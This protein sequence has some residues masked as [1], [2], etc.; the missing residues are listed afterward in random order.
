MRECF[1]LLFL[2]ASLRLVFIGA[3]LASASR[4]WNSWERRGEGGV[5][6]IISDGVPFFSSKI[7]CSS[8]HIMMF[9]LF[10]ACV[11]MSLGLGLLYSYLVS[12]TFLILISLGVYLLDYDYAVSSVYA[13]AAAINEPKIPGIWAVF[14]VDSSFFL[15]FVSRLYYSRASRGQSAVFFFFLFLLLGPALLLF[16]CSF[17]AP[18][19]LTTSWYIKG[20]FFLSFGFIPYWTS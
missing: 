18:S 11:L 10:S 13:S 7:F 2:V 20:F 14:L 16:L 15:T 8:H 6:L 19:F 5:R 12:F 3:S 9:S 17:L 1:Y 4:L